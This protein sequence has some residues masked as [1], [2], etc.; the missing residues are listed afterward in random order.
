M[1]CV[2]FPDWKT[3]EMVWNNYL[4]STVRFK[5]HDQSIFLPSGSFWT[6]IWTLAKLS[7]KQRS[8]RLEKTPLTGSPERNQ[9]GWKSCEPMHIRWKMSCSRRSMQSAKQFLVA[10]KPRKN[11]SPAGE[12][13]RQ[14]CA[15][16]CS[17]EA[18]IWPNGVRKKK[19]K[20]KKQT[21]TKSLILGEKQN[22][23]LSLQLALEPVTWPNNVRE[24]KKKQPKFSLQEFLAS[25]LKFTGWM[26]RT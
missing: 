21:K 8:T 25:L 26:D 13:C 17:L 12:G 4:C 23:R 24:R 6:E 14:K 16:A 5:S 7:K 19:K 9:K 10:N 15:E 2:V 1:P 11:S 18:V 22:G 3:Y 20:N